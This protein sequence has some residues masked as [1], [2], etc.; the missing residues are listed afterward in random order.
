MDDHPRA[1]ASRTLHL[2]LEL[3]VDRRPISGVLRT[4][5]GA[6]ERFVGW[7]GFLGSLANLQGADT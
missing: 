7:L 5:D 2:Q 1:D 3:D 6:E 4:T